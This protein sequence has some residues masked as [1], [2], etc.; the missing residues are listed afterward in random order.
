M[1]SVLDCGEDVIFV[2]GEQRVLGCLLGCGS[3]DL[4]LGITQRP[5]EWLGGLE[6]LSNDLFGG[7]GVTLL[8][9]LNGGVGRFRL[10]HHDRDIVTDHATS[11]HHVEGSFLQLLVSRECHPLA[12]DQSHPHAADR[13]AERQTSQHGGHRGGVNR[14]DVVK[15]TGVQ[16]Q[17]GNHDLYFVAETL[18]ERGT[19]RP[20]D[21]PASQNRFFTGTT[22]APEK[23]AGNPPDRVHP[24]F[25]V[26]RQREEVEMLFGLFRC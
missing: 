13:A 3:C 18:D 26:H 12:V 24:L 7:R 2:V 16:R 25:N 9:Q 11:D 4:A 20:V 21:Q 14:H 22:F 6:P 10:H 19:Q 15:V 8:H 1:G 17:D 5:N 23:R